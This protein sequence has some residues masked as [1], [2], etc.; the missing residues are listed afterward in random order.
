MPLGR[1]SLSV[2]YKTLSKKKQTVQP[3]T[4]SYSAKQARKGKDIGKPGKNFS[5][6]AKSVAKEYG[7]KEAEKRVAGA[8]LSKLRTKHG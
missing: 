5:K 8:I 3:G 2:V 7:S 6:I 1:G 4:K